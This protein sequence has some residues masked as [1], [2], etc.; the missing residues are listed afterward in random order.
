MS[1]DKDPLGTVAGLLAVH[2]FQPA[3]AFPAEYWDFGDGNREGE[4]AQKNLGYLR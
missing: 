4:R 2:L 3:I 1:R